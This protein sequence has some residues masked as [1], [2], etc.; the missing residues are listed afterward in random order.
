MICDT[1][2]CS[3]HTKETNGSDLCSL[4]I[5][6][7][8]MVMNSYTL[9]PKSSQKEANSQLR[10]FF[11]FLLLYNYLWY[12]FYFNRHL[13]EIKIFLSQFSVSSTGF[14]PGIRVITKLWVG[15]CVTEVII[16]NF[17]LTI[18]KVACC[19]NLWEYMYCIHNLL[20]C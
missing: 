6:A 13:F 9:Y 2:E 18:C 1:A 20:F 15:K 11:L 12:L 19:E 5:C 10:E 8:G 17:H 3:Y 4:N 14:P 7:T 16:L